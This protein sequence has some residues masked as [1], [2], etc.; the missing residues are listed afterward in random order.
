M[1]TKME[2]I[3]R[4]AVEHKASDVH[5]ISDVSPKIRV[6]GELLDVFGFEKVG[7]EIISE[8]VL[9]LLTEKQLEIFKK[10]KE[11]DFSFEAVDIR[12]RAN[13]YLQKDTPSC[14][15]RL[16]SSEI[17]TFEELNIPNILRDFT[18]YKQGF[19][20]VTGPTGHGKSTTVA[21]LLEEINRSIGG[22]IV[23]IEDPVEYL[24]K[25][26]KA[27]ISQREMGGDTNS[28][29]LALRSCLRQDPNVVFL[30]EMR[31]LES[32][33]SALTI[34]ETGHLVFS[35][36]HTNSAAQTVDRIVDQFP[37][38][39]KD[40]IR[41]QLATVITAIVSQRLVPAIDGSRI[42][43]FEILIA[44][45][46]VRNVIREGKTFMIDNIIQTSSDAGMISF[47]TYMTKLVLEGKVTEEV[48]MTYAANAIELQS[49]LRRQK[50]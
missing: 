41:V 40:Q 13:V 38:G 22:H 34:A 11:L 3:L 15:L 10:E 33:S 18:K 28:F 26:E 39:S 8:M 23:T 19:V 37:S 7:N 12:F 5:L 36:L 35:V 32:T 4:Y 2:E 49:K 43:V 27:I 25:P 48:A 50:L 42:P 30:G 24:I 16:I 14:A 44:T 45:P 20:L 29:S 6:N 17:P 1:N 21:A 46:A 31:D 9:S 47:D